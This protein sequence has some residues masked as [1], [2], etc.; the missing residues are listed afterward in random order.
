MRATLKAACIFM[1]TLSTDAASAAAPPPFPDLNTIL[2]ET[3]FKILGPS[4]RQLGATAVG[5]GFIVGKPTKEG[6]QSYFVLVTA[7][8]VLEDIGGDFAT[9]N[10]REKQSDGSYTS[11]DR[12]FQIRDQ[13]KNIYVRH[14]DVDVA[15]IY[16]ALPHYY[17]G[18]V[19]IGDGLLV[20]EE[21]ILKFEIH[22]GD[23]LLCLG[24]PLGASGPYGFPILRSGKIASFPLAP[25]KIHKHWLFDFRVFGGN[26]GGPVYM[27]DRGRQYE[28][29]I[30]LDQT[31]Q[32]VLGLVTQQMSADPGTG[33]RELQLGVVIPSQFI[34]ETMDMLPDVPPPTTK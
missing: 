29:T 2:M 31:V 22:P 17:K 28:G 18:K 24:Y 7:A 33:P 12:P 16:V 20:S 5:T 30:H 8:H 11:V 15:S 13:G 21:E 23:E 6:G 19:Q 25:V 10:V 1:S 9:I 32:M 26:S 34:K 3:T 4:A 27:V 14:P